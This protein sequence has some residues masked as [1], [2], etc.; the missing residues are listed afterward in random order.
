MYRVIFKHN[1]KEGQGEAYI[2]QWQKGSDIIQ[3]YPGA[4]GTKLYKKLDEPGYLYAMADWESKEVRTKAIEAIKRDRPDAEEVLHK[5]EQ[6]LNSHITF[7]EFELIAKSDPP[8]KLYRFSPIK[9]QEELLKTI[10]HTH[11]E[12]HKLCKQ[13]L[14]KYL[15]VAGNMGIFCHYE[16]EYKYLTDLRKQITEPSDNLNKKYFPLYEPITISAQGD[17]PETTYTH[18]YIRKPDPYRAQ[19]GNVDFILEEPNYSELKNSLLDSS[20][21]KGARVFPRGDLDMIE[22]YDP[23]SDALGYLSP[24]DMTEKVRVKQQ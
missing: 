17:I 4:L 5:H 24:K 16:D 13:S 8:M 9:S 19:V 7:G 18:L 10:K 12:C 2:S 3:S 11:L 14:D 1:L 22:L 21:I 6:F 15:S 20:Q 23:D